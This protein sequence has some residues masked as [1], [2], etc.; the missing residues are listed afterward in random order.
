MG[1]FVPVR[2]RIFHNLIKSWVDNKPI[3]FAKLA[4]TSYFNYDL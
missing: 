2:M 1:I 4:A 3:S